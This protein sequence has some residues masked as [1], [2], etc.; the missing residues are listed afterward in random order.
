MATPKAIYLDHNATTPLDSRV[1]EAMMPFLTDEFGNAASISHGYG[2]RAREAVEHAREQVAALIGAESKSIVFTSGAT[3][4]DNLAIKGVA[5]MYA[6]KGNHIITCATEHKAVLDT[7]KYL[8]EKGF[9]VTFLAPDEF[10]RVSAEQVAA[11][12]TDQ[13]ILI[14]LMAANNE[15][16]TI[17]PVAEIGQLAKDRGVLF[18]CDATQAIGK[19]LVDV[20][21][22]NIDLL[23]LSAHKFYGPKG[24]GALFVRRK[25]PR[26]RL[27]I[28]THGGGHENGFRSGTLNVPGIVGLGAAAEL[29]GAEMDA[30]AARLKKLK[31]RLEGRLMEQ[32][33]YVTLNGH[34]TE[35]LPNTTNLSFGYVEGESLMLKMPDVAVSAA[36]ACTSESLEPSFV[37]KAIGVPDELAHGSIRFSLGRTTTAEQ[38]DHVVGQVVKAVNE[39]REMSPLYEMVEEGIDL[40]SLEWDEH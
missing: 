40:S 19:V 3:E 30:E 20:E 34:P 6:S 15:I 22:M 11:A 21:E 8:T 35:R 13:T 25:K 33:K 4:S 39:L 37:L 7:C 2:M 26:A 23:S 12:V 38:I 10:G 18:H 16:G 28:Q 31:G 27:A 14:S 36:S 1:L 9:E 24:V 29:A 32:L 5:E 17:H